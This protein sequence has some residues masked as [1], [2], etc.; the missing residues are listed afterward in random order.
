MIAIGQIFG[1]PTAVA[2]NGIN[3]K[4]DSNPTRSEIPLNR[5]RTV[6]AR[7]SHDTPW[8]SYLDFS[9]GRDLAAE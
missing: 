5:R 3:E 9:R 2:C 4:I 8:R 7:G 1:H 6:T